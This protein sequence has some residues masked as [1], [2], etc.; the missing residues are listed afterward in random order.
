M[1]A[2]KRVPI[3]IDCDPGHDDAVALLLAVASPALDLRLVSVVAGNQT[4]DRT[5]RNAL[6]VLTVA[7]A[8]HVPV[9]AG[10]DRPLVRPRIVAGHI[11]GE[12]G[13]DGPAMPEPGFA[14]SSRHAV[15]LII[16]TLTTSGEPITLIPVGP[17]TNIA[18]ALRMAPHIASRIKE[19]VL[20]GGSIGLGNT[21][22]AAEFNIHADPEA[23]AIVFGSGVPIT[24]I[25]LDVTYQTQATAARRA[26]IDALNSPI[27]GLVG[28]WLD[29]FGGRY[30]EVY[31][32]DGPPLHDPC[33]VAQV[34]RPGLV[35]TMPMSVEIDIS[36]G[37]SY[38]RTVCDR[39][40]VTGRP[41]NA[42]VGLDIEVD[43]FYD[44]LI[45]TLARYR[46]L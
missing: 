23:A 40:G 15:D 39:R 46:A 14:P 42:E 27:A 41:A 11:H 26:R 36:H 37:P 33:A 17:L 8:S 21:T 28:G 45:D 19:I 12:S 9:A 13:L 44:M 38:G 43:G 35:R 34:I 4:L 31:G 20:M 32:L 30:R 16:E 24:M 10:A 3:I 2:A 25:G 5:V 18:L 1:A 6:S 7:G 22:P 29:F